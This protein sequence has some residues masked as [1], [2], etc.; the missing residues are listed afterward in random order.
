MAL[1]SSLQAGVYTSLSYSTASPATVSAADTVAE[2]LAVLAVSAN[3]KEIPCI[4]EFPEF[5]NPANI[6]KVP[7]Y[8]AKTSHQVSGQADSM[9]MTFTVNYVPGDAVL[10]DLQSRVGDGNLYVFQIGICQ[11][12]PVGT[13]A[14]SALI[15]QK[16]GTAVAGNN[17]NALFYFV[18][19][20]AAMTYGT[21]LTDA[22]TTKLSLT[23][24]TDLL[25][26][27]TV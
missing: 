14:T 17:P 22:L 23:M 16:K 20:V 8:G 1:P 6:V 2:C 10:V 4:R 13:A 24:E 12:E 11:S 18:G 19:K 7:C 9:D 26:P 25:G 3:V 5:G 21:S 15:G 27:T